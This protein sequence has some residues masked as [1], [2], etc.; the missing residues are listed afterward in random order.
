MIKIPLKSWFDLAKPGKWNTDSGELVE[1]T[2]G[3][4]AGAV[5]SF[6]DSKEQVLIFK[7]TE[8]DSKSI[9]VGVVDDLLFDGETFY[10]S[11]NFTDESFVNDMDKG[12]FPFPVP[13]F[14]V[15]N[16][17]LNS[18]RFLKKNK[19]SIA[20]LSPVLNLNLSESMESNMEQN[21]E[22]FIQVGRSIAELANKTH[23]FGACSGK[24]ASCV[25][26]FNFDTL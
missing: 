23:D 21:S 24:N 19:S 12:L 1:L 18:I 2:P 15:N 5:N 22:N 16:F 7:D 10:F 8:D 9:A 13:S 4:L 20:G 6:K 11:P 25:S 14:N 3:R 17:T 26:I